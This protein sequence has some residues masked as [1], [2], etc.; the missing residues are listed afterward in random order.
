MLV[1]LK[2]QVGNI[3]EAST[4]W[5][6]Q[7][8]PI[9]RAQ[10]CYYVDITCHVGVVCIWPQQ[11]L[12]AQHHLLVWFGIACRAQCDSHS[13]GARNSR[14]MEPLQGDHTLL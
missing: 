9:S 8:R 7:F 4:A 1:G 12:S 2:N 6:N 13:G 14:H 10:H 11:R 5:V 3:T